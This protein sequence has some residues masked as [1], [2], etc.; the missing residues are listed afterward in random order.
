MGEIAQY[1]EDLRRDIKSRTEVA[2]VK[3]GNAERK[4]T[5]FESRTYKVFLKSAHQDDAEQVRE[6][7]AK[8][9]QVD[10]YLV[11]DERKSHHILI[12]DAYDS[13]T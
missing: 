8:E 3:I 5:E 12:S 2:S 1:F 7:L 13:A 9:L 10:A 6:E 11:D 4:H